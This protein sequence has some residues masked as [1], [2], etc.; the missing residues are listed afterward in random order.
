MKILST[1]K[2]E[3]ACEG[4]YWSQKMCSSLLEQYFEITKQG[5]CPLSSPIPQHA[6][7][8]SVNPES[9]THT[10]T[11]YYLH[12]YMRTKKTITRESMS[13]RH[14]DWLEM[15]EEEYHK[16]LDWEW[17]HWWHWRYQSRKRWCLDFG[18]AIH[19]TWIWGLGYIEGPNHS[20]LLHTLSCSSLCR[21]GS[22]RLHP[23]LLSQT[24]ALHNHIFSASCHI[25]LI[26]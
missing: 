8:T 18:I 11:C 16:K 2:R 19:A 9:N 12:Y 10:H 25:N 23:L 21:L 15:N 17:G 22:T 26:Y 24:Y 14:R 20:L 6:A 13:S 4:W 5:P 7:L 1:N 3:A